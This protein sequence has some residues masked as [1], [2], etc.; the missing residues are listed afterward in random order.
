MGI[1][2]GISNTQA[3]NP[4][5]VVPPNAVINRGMVGLQDVGMDQ[6]HSASSSY[7]AAPSHGHSMVFICC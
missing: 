1:V 5:I 7:V 6:N 4:I 3:C 2:R